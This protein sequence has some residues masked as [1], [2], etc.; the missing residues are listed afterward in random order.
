MNRPVNECGCMQCRCCDIWLAACG[1]FRL[2]NPPP[3]PVP[4]EP[5]PVDVKKAEPRHLFSEVE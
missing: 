4:V 3:K 1:V 5:E 2:P